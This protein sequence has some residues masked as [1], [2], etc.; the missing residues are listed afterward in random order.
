MFVKLS[1]LRPLTHFD[2]IWSGKV[3]YRRSTTPGEL[4]GG[5]DHDHLSSGNP[6]ARFYDPIKN[7]GLSWLSY[8]SIFA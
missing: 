1:W 8:S 3:C 6:H 7:R 2:E 5:G 4:L